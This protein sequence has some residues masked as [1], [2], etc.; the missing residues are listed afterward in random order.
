MKSMTGF[1]V[2]EMQEEGVSASIEMK[3]YNSRFLDIFVNL[4]PFLSVLESEIRDYV[5]SRFR[6]GKVEITI[7]VREL[8]SDIA[9]SVN[10]R[11]ARVYHDSILALAQDLGLEEKPGLALILGMEGVLEIEKNRDEQRCRSIIA[12]LLQKAAD[13]FEAERVREGRTAQADI[14]THLASLE[15]G[16]AAIASQAPLMEISI[17]ENLRSRF[18][19]LLGDRIDENRVLAETA[20]LLMKYTISEELSRLSSHLEEFRLE[21]GRNPSPG[22]KL[23]FLC[24]EINREINTIGSK[25]PVLEVSRAVVSMKDA[26]ENIREQLRN[27][28]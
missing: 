26:L 1:A 10:H 19:E 9:V 21:T 15:T 24:Q 28:E 5:G 7:R 22:K 11:A 6:R 23:D 2:Q 8:N 27:V 20:A 13:Q 14:L 18:A 16:L 25:T 17:K 12:P 4:P 3:G